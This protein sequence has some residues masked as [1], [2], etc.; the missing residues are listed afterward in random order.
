MCKIDSVVRKM[1]IIKRVLFHFLIS[2]IFSKAEVGHLF[3]NFLQ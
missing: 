2:V 1:S 3:I